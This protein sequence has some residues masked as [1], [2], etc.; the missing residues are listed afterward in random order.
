MRSKTKRML[1]RLGIVTVLLAVVAMGYLYFSNR[2]NDF[3]SESERLEEYYSLRKTMEDTYF[4]SVQDANDVKEDIL[5]ATNKVSYE[6]AV[7]KYFDTHFDT[8]SGPLADYSVMSYFGYFGVDKSNHTIQDLFL[9]EKV[10]KWYGLDQTLL[11]DGDRTVLSLPNIG[12]GKFE[13][14]YNDWPDED[15]F[16]INIKTLLPSDDMDQVRKELNTVYKSAENRKQL[17]I[18]LRGSN[19]WGADFW[20]NEIVKPLL[21]GK[22]EWE[23]W[24]FLKSDHDLAYYNNIGYHFERI[25][26]IGRESIPSEY[27]SIMQKATLAHVE[28]QSIEGGR[29]EEFKGQIYILVDKNSK[30]SA[31]EFADFA[32]KTGFA[33]VVGEKTVGNFK[34]RTPKFYVMEHSGVVISIYDV[35]YGVSGGEGNPLD[36]FEPEYLVENLNER[37]DRFDKGILFILNSNEHM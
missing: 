25:E 2:P 4:Y 20:K 11:K 27:E 19:G 37:V 33:T 16:Y 17:I 18:D 15:T 30:A 35:I 7:L 32:K 14:S 12:N 6:A 13:Y 9:Q 3:I 31:V 23:D 24:Y 29:D 36:G 26:A 21:K 22:L 8:W 34:E 28:K 10:L 5:N 1:K